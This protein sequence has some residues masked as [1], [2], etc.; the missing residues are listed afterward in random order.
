MHITSR[1]TDFDPVWDALSGYSALVSST[2]ESFDFKIQHV[3]AA[4]RTRVAVI[5]VDV[6]R[7]TTTLLAAGAAGSRGVH[8]AVKPREGRYDLSPSF[9]GPDEWIYGGEE[10][11]RAIP[12]GKIGNSPLD[13]SK[14]LVGGRYLKFFST[15]G[16]RAVTTVDASG[17]GGIFLA[18]LV[19]VELTAIEAIRRGYSF[20]WFVCGGF[21]GSS[22]LEDVVCAGRGIQSLLRGKHVSLDSLD[23]EARIAVNNA[24]MYEGDD[25]QFLDDL[26]HGQV[27][28][29]L[30]HIGR[31]MDLDAVVRGTGLDS[32]LWSRMATTLMVRRSIAG[33]AV[34]VAERSEVTRYEHP[35]KAISHY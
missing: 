1:N 17:V 21:Y 32:A 8:F 14:G 3:P 10:N 34:F 18:S 2:P 31:G 22:T 12:G 33:A 20:V 6:L 11:G 30:N 27:G 24:N 35:L 5:L 29:L 19:N 26:R 23:D 25:G 13:V 28:I 9:A 7:A 15:N 4:Q 16:A